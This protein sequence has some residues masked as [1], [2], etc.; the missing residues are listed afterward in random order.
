MILSCPVCDTR[1]VVPDS[2]IGANGRQVRC[3]NCKN[4]WFQGPPP[5]PKSVMPEERAEPPAAVAEDAAPIAAA[6]PPEHAVPQPFQST[7]TPFPEPEAADEPIDYDA[8]AQEPPFSGR[9]NPAR[10]WTI[11]AIIAAVLMLGAVAAIWAFGLP[12]QNVTKAEAATPLEIK[13]NGQPERRQLES[14]NELLAVS[15]RIVNPTE[16]TQRVPQIRAELRD[17]QGRVVYGWFISAPVP[18]L[19]PGQ[20]TVFNSAEVD[21]PRGAKRLNLSFGQFS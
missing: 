8:Y 4:S 21:V 1:Y 7:P 6:P 20:S 18:E 17:V 19:A 15:G 12:I 13:V 11:I 2:A 16:Q 14:G 3:A 10:L 9:R 5:A